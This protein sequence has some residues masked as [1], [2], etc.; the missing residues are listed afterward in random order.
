VIS[1]KC[2]YKEGDAEIEIPEF[3]FKCDE[4][5]LDSK[6][7][8]KALSLSIVRMRKEEVSKI[9]I[10]MEFFFKYLDKNKDMIKETKILFDEEFR[11]AHLHNYLLFEVSLHN[12]YTVQNLMDHGEIKKRI[13][14]NGKSWKYARNPDIV[15][16]NLYCYHKESLV[17]HRENEKVELDN[18]PYLHEIEKRCVQN[19]KPGEKAEIIVQPSYLRDKN[20]KFLQEFKILNET[21][22]TFKVEVKDITVFDYIFKPDKDIIPKKSIL[23]KGFGKD[24]P[25]RESTVLI[26]LQ[27]RLNNQILFNN[28]EVE[29]VREYVLNKC[30]IKEYEDWRKKINEQYNIQQLDLEEQVYETNLEIFEKFKKEFNNCSND[31]DSFLNCD[32]RLYSLPMVVR[33]VLIHMKRN[34]VT[35]IKTNVLDYFYHSHNS[36]ELKDI[37]TGKEAK[38]EIFI[39]LFEFLHR[40]LFSKLTIEEKF[41]ELSEMK[42][43]ANSFFKE[44]KLFRASKLY[45]NINSRFNY[46]GVFGDDFEKGEKEHIDKYPELTSQLMSIR[47][48]CHNNL[49]SAKFKL[50]KYRSVYEVTK[51]VVQDFDPNN[52]KALYLKG[53]SCLCLKQFEEAIKDFTKLNQLNENDDEFRKSLK[54]A[55]DLYQQDLQKERDRCKKMLKFI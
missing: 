44:G 1:S 36:I 27:I 50:G 11:K 19:V 6:R 28:F 5:D 33:K 41:K 45:Q 22:T 52:T 16:F 4:M 40:K 30:N 31:P 42:E 17:Y 7:V 12:W 39:H 38:V 23:S 35:Y 49:A 32:L 54:E 18:C 20:P 15:V 8:P 24:S 37:N 26:K 51:K 34:E 9:S 46:G 21:P 43:L 2:Y 3:T 47:L 48:A 13:L 53:K 25:D 55:E 10:R 14:V 29:D